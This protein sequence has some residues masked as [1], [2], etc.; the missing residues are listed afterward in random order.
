MTMAKGHKTP[1]A[2]P[3]YVKGSNGTK[4][5]PKTIP[6]KPVSFQITQNQGLFPAK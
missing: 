2:K 1:A 4:P 3:V 6:D 5:T